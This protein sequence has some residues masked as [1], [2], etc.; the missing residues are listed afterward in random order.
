MSTVCTYEDW[1]DRQSVKL[2]IADAEKAERSPARSIKDVLGRLYGVDEQ[3][4][5]LRAFCEGKIRR[6]VS[7]AMVELEDRDAVLEILDEMR[8]LVLKAR[9]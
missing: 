4:E 2:A 5:K 3:A 8:V 9:L 6:E 1:R 7:N